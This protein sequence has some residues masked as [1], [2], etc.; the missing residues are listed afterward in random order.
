MAKLRANDVERLLVSV[1][2]FPELPCVLVHLVRVTPDLRDG[3]N[4]VFCTPGR[5]TITF[6]TLYELESSHRVWRTQEDFARSECGGGFVCVVHQSTGQVSQG[7]SKCREVWY[8]V[9]QGVG[10]L[11]YIFPM[12]R[13]R[14]YIR[15]AITV[16]YD[17]RMSDVM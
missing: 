5:Q 3:V 12:A 16:D 4:F 2:F 8:L 15:C 10:E 7:D 6:A 13:V 9:A 11:L 14:A 1:F 17:S